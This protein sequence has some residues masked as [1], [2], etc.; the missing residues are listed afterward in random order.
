MAILI[1]ATSRYE[2]S[3]FGPPHVASHL[4]LRPQAAFWRVD[5]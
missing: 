5:R 3:P 4:H 2:S 1:R